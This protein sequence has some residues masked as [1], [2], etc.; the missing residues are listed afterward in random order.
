MSHSQTVP[1]EVNRSMGNLR[2][3]PRPTE[4]RL[5]L[6]DEELDAGA[7]SILAAEKRLTRA[8]QSLL[9]EA[10]IN[11]RELDVLIAIRAVP[12]QTVRQMRERLAMTVPTFARI[13]GR[14]DQQGL[15]EKSLSVDDMRARALHLSPDGETLLV[16]FVARLRDVLRSAYRDVGAEHVIG[17][18]AVLEA[19]AAHED[20]NE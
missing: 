3:P 6:R 5:F 1:T 7:A 11:E 14:L 12:G 17:A 13:L 9:S 19:I 2:S 8:M 16:P 4:G 10:P 20:T 15:I 18:R